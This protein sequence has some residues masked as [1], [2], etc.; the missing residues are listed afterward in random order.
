[1]AEMSR[2]RDIRAEALRAV[3]PPPTFAQAVESCID[4]PV[5]EVYNAMRI[6]W[7]DNVHAIGHWLVSGELRYLDAVS[8]NE[9]F[10]CSYSADQ[11]WFTRGDK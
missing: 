6:E 7:R 11:C 3:G 9:A 1:M 2:E 8:G 10:A 5:A 4:T